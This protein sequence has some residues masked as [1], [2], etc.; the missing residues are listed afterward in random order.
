MKTPHVVCEGS[1]MQ[2]VIPFGDRDTESSQTSQKLLSDA[3]VRPYMRPRR[4]K[5]GLHRAQVSDEFTNWFD[6]Q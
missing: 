6:E 1:S 3:W 4:L 5:D 2:A